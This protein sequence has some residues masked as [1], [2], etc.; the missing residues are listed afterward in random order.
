MAPHKSTNGCC[1]QG[2]TA[3]Y[4]SNPQKGVFSCV[5][6]GYT[7]FVIFISMFLL[8]VFDYLQIRP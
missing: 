3:G 8:Y 1:V 5:V 2:V 7:E 4:Y 6:K